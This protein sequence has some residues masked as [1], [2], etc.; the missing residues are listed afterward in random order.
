[1]LENEKETLREEIRTRREALSSKISQYCTAVREDVKAEREKFATEEAAEI[2]LPPNVLQFAD[3]LI[4]LYS[5]LLL[6]WPNVPQDIMGC[7]LEGVLT[8]MKNK[9]GN[10]QY[11][12]NK[13]ESPQAEE[14]GQLNRRV[15]AMLWELRSTAVIQAFSEW[16]LDEW[17]KK[18]VN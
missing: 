14:I 3:G 16:I 6:F 13:R 10:V 5:Q 17:K 12:L 15:C 2:P 8:K 1:M 9:N 11:K 7:N 4:S 18:I